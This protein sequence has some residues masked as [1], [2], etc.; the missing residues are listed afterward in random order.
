[1]QNFAT[2]FC[3]PCSRTHWEVGTIVLTV[4]INGF[5]CRPVYINRFSAIVCP[6]HLVSL[7]FSKTYPPVCVYLSADKI[8]FLPGSYVDQVCWW[9]LAV[10]LWVVPRVWSRREKVTRALKVFPARRA[11]LCWPNKE[12]YFLNNQNSLMCARLGQA[13]FLLFP[14]KLSAIFFYK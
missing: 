3:M 4:F 1:M 11:V 2:T 6:V 14:F 12:K 8:I 9:L 10:C 5:S 7:N 13:V